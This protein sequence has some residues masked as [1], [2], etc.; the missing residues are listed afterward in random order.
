MLWVL[1]GN[2]AAQHFYSRNGW[3]RDDLGRRATVWGV[4]VDEVRYR[5]AIPREQRGTDAPRAEADAGG[6]P[7]SDDVS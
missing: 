6:I 5:R 7:K 3:T 2:R 4:T 1:T